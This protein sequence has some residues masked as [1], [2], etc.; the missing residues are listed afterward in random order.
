MTIEILDVV[1]GPAVVGLGPGEEEVV[2]PASDVL[3]VVVKDAEREAAL[4][5]E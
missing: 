5:A 3:D 4:I 2:E 1:V